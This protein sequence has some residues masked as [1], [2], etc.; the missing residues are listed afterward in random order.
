MQTAIAVFLAAVGIKFLTFTTGKVDLVLNSLGLTFI[1]ELDQVVFAAIIAKSHQSFVSNLQPVEYVSRLPKRYLNV[2]RFTF[3]AF[4]I[5][6]CMLA[7]LVTRHYQLEQFGSL[8]NTVSTLCLFGGTP[9]NS[10][11]QDH[12]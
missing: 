10:V 9:R 3:P 11:E 1:L 2:H 12:Y 8:F 4:A 6:L 7:S 5:V